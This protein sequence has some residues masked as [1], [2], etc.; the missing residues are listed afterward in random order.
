MPSSC[1]STLGDPNSFGASIVYSL[2]L[3]AARWRS[4]DAAAAV[5]PY[6]PTRYWLAWVDLLRDPV[7]IEAGAEAT[8]QPIAELEGKIEVDSMITHTMPLEEITTAF[9]DYRFNEAT[10]TLYRF[11]WSEYCDWG[12]ELAKVR[13]QDEAQCFYFVADWHGL[14]THYETPEVIGASVWDMLI[15]WLAAVVTK[16]STTRDGV[17]ITV[18]DVANVSVGGDLRTGAAT[19][20]GREVVVGTVLMITGGN[21]RTVAAAAARTAA[22]P[23]PP[24]RL[25]DALERGAHGH[26]PGHVQAFR[27]VYRCFRH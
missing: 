10:Q 14:T 22:P 27:P 19:S 21:S 15:D 24:H 11:F 13:L 23:L 12:L 1:H 18:R 20:G 7:R 4:L 26:R 8:E 2:P 16:M 17:P 25:S 5:T 3:V 9:A 6:L